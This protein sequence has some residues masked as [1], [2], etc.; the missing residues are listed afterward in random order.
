MNG[1]EKRQEQARTIL[2]LSTEEA[3]K[4]FLKISVAQQAALALS[5]PEG[6]RRMDFILLSNR[7]QELIRE[8][9]PE[10]FVLTIKDIGDL[11]AVP[12]LDLSTNSQLTYLL[13]LELWIQQGL[14]LGRFFHWL[15]LLFECGEERV[16][17]WVESVDFELLV[18]AFE[19][20]VL[21]LTKDDL[22]SLPELLEGRVI[23]P[24]NTH[25]F[26]VKLGADLGLM[27]RLIDLMFGNAQEQ[28]FALTGNL[29]TNP[30]AE[31]EEQT[32]RWRNGRLADRGWPD[33]EEA[34]ALYHPRSLSAVRRTVGLPAEMERSPRYPL[35][36]FQG[37]SLLALGLSGIEDE[38]TRARIASQLANLINR[39]IVGEGWLPGELTSLEKGIQRIHGRLEIGLALLGVSSADSAAQVLSSVPLLDLAQVAQGAIQERVS[40]ARKLA[41]STLGCWFS[42][43]PDPLPDQL[44][45]L[46]LRRPLMLG[47]GDGF[48]RE[49]QRVADLTE[50]DASLL[51][52]E[53]LLALAGALGLGEAA[54][55]EP[56]PAGSRP[57]LL[58]ELTLPTLLLTAFVRDQLGLSPSFAPVPFGELSL[59]AQGLP[60]EPASLR[61]KLTDWAV[62]A[63][64][65]L[66][67]GWP[68]FAEALAHTLQESVLSRA[69]GSLDP[70][71]IEGL[72]IALGSAE[73]N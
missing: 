35:E 16:L 41:V 39:V 49:L 2:K 15:A 57:A 45:A 11:D 1:L 69:P 19:R 58:A 70:R 21:L 34:F 13:D 12:L 36:R 67:A 61:L 72:W 44:K 55:A 37:L 26:A 54:L 10:D 73:H 31:L 4:R 27:R 47:Q 46:L 53:A 50:L 52:A 22:D 56:L 60:A 43:L 17:R 29:G 18:L 30:M 40:R 51:R 7:P 6:R 14:D 65:A 64:P 62:A 8:I 66:C 59:L 5:L 71:F 32:L 38:P 20:L 25:F 63:L 42:N 3:G 33:V 23:T 68:E 9:S 48:P 24:D 28:L